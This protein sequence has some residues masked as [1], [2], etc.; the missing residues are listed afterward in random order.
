MFRTKRQK[1][2]T[3]AI[4]RE[5]RVTDAVT[6]AAEI[7]VAVDRAVSEMFDGLPEVWVPSGRSAEASAER[8]GSLQDMLDQPLLPGV[9]V[10]E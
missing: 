6:L 1:L 9:V 7:N 3:A 2:T 5:K 8:L 4:R 10:W